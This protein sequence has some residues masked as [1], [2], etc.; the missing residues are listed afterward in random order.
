M[1]QSLCWGL[2]VL[3][4]LAH[5]KSETVLRG[6]YVFHLTEETKAQRNVVP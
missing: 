1:S 6:A 5:S 4:V 3:T 2:H